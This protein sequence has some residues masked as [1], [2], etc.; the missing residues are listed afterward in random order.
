MR[1]FL[2]VIFFIFLNVISAQ[3]YK[4]IGVKDGD[5]VVLLIDGKPETVRLSHIDCPEKKQ[6]FGN[7]A[8]IFVSDLCF[9]Q[10]VNIKWDGK[11][12]RYKR[13]LAEVI[14]QNGTNVNKE[15]LKNGLAW[16]FKKYS[17]DQ[18]YAALEI[19]AR[20]KKS[21][22]WIGKNPIAPWEWRKLRKLRSQHSFSA[23]F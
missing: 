15:L 14:L 11:K 16:H 18:N 2:T 17:K 5:T 19:Y 10:F 21:G 8:K 1:L 12:D 9:G 13:I 4:V 3:T 22:L 23:A 20:R 6:P 7:N